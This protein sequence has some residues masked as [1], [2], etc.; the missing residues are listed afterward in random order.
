MN[1]RLLSLAF[2]V[3]FLSS[4]NLFAQTEFDKKFNDHFGN[5]EV[6]TFSMNGK[7]FATG[8]WDNMINVY[9]G[10][11][12]KLIS[13]LYGHGAAVTSISIARNNKSIV[14]IV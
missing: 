7:Y 13:S 4:F 11:S 2:T 12:A 14:N 6:A 1:V 8:A 10:D 9:S 3:V 5:V